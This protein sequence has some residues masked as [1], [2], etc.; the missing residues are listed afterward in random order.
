MTLLGR[1]LHFH[2]IVIAFWMINDTYQM[3]S[4]AHVFMVYVMMQNVY[5]FI[6]TWLWFD[7]QY[8]QIMDMQIIL[9]QKIRVFH[10]PSHVEATQMSS[11]NA[12]LQTSYFE[13]WHMDMGTSSL[14]H[15]YIC[16]YIF[17]I[18]VVFM[19]Y[20]WTMK[21]L[22]WWHINF[23]PLVIINDSSLR[24]FY[25]Y[26]SLISVLHNVTQPMGWAPLPKRGRLPLG[27]TLGP[28]S[29]GANSRPT[30]HATNATCPPN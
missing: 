20:L 18:Y 27:H 29:R 3:H 26:I 21:I 14:F 8:F 16:I 1:I 30:W 12:Y 10:G 6:F 22:H 25:I 9:I 23:E 11:L 5:V 19:L 2:Q 24:R 28:T 15:I 13:K 7:V 17:I 4:R